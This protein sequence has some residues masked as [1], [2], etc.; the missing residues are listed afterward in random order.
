MRC[1][2][3]GR[4][5]CDDKLMCIYS[6]P[7][8]KVRFTGKNGQEIER[9]RALLVLAVGSVYEVT[10]TDVGKCKS[11]TALVGVKGFFNT[12]MFERV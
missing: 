10:S 1:S 9:E 4:R 3:R 6:P 12:V 8:T 2:V 5:D 7:G 11:W